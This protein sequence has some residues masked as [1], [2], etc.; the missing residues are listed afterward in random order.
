MPFSTLSIIHKNKLNRIK[1]QYVHNIWSKGFIITENNN[2]L[3]FHV[4]KYLHRKAHNSSC[5]FVELK[6]E[7]RNLKYLVIRDTKY[8]VTFKFKK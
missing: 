3:C 2:K 1:N 6:I 8:F 7:Y 5:R 4:K